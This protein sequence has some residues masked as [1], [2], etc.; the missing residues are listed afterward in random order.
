MEPG[1]RRTKDDTWKEDEL[2]KHLWAA[3]SASPTE[4]T[5]PRAGKPRRESEA[6]RSDRKERRAGAP[7][8]DAEYRESAAERDGQAARERAR[9][10]GDTDRP[11]DS[12][13]DTGRPKEKHRARGAEKPHGRGKERES[14]R[15]R[16]EE[17]RQ[18][19]AH[20]SLLGHDRDR[21]ERRRAVSKARIAE[22]ERRDED[23]ERGD[24]ERE[25]RYRERKLQY[26]DSKDN[27][28]KYWLYKE[29]GERRHR[30]QKEPDREKKH[31]EKSSTREKREKYSK[32]KSHSFSDKEGAERR[33]EQ[34]HKEGF[35]VDE[36]EEQHRRG[37]AKVPLPGASS[38]QEKG[39]SERSQ[40]MGLLPKGSDRGENVRQ[41]G[42]RRNRGASSK[43]DGTGSQ[44]AENLERN[45]GK[46]KDSRRKHGREEGPSA[47]KLAR[48]Q[49][50]EEALEIEKE[51][52]DLENAGADE[53]AAS[54]EADFEDYEGDFEVCDGDSDD[55]A[56]EPESGETAGQLPLARRREIQEVQKAIHAENERVGELFS[57]LFEKRGRTERG[58][59]PGPAAD[60]S[61]SETPACGIFLDFATASRRQKSRTQALKQKT[62]STKLLRLIDLD[63]SFTFSLLDLPPV[64]EY[65]MYIRNFGKKNTKQVIA[66]LLEEDRVALEPI[67]TPR[68]QDCTLRFSDSSAQLNTSLPFLQNR[69]VSYLHASQVQR[70]MV[71][72]V[73]GRAGKAFAPLLDGRYVL[74]VWD[75][76]QPSGPQKVLIC[77]S[78]VTCCCFSPLKAF[79]LFAGTVHGS[80]VV[81]DLREDARLHRYVKLSG[82]FWTFR[83]ATFSTDGVLMS[84][85]HRSP[86]Q[87][88]E[89]IAGSVCKR[90]S[91]VLSP[92]STQEEPAGL[93]FHVASLDESGVLN[94][95]V[96][97]ELAKADTAGAISDLGLLPG[98]RI[99]LVHSAAIQLSDSVS[100]KGYEFWGSTQTLNVKFLPSDPNHFVVGT[101]MGLISHGTRQDVRVSPRLFRPQQQGVRPVKVNV[102]DFSPFGE[103]IFLAGCSDGSIRLHQLTAE[104][105]L[106]Q[107]DKSTHGR[108]VTGLQ[109]S[110]T[111]P[112]VFLVQDDTSCVY[113]WDLLESD[114]GPVAK[115]PV[116]PDRLVAMTVVGEAEKTRSGFL[117]LVLARASGDVDVQYLRREWVAP[118]GDE[119]Q[120]LRLLLRKAL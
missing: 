92:F 75:I 100:H 35:R 61:P 25:R 73:H 36:E 76:W 59:G 20:P 102:I 112:A 99:K 56:H 26:G 27:P 18:V 114:L 85:N 58:R 13:R 116:S 9:G 40:A 93:S 104:H 43:T 19:A 39:T 90:Q 31:R 69:R 6:D 17:L 38:S 41:N 97:V 14:G 66:V 110:S 12:R 86:L 37:E 96:V 77:E 10:A 30:K 115:Q 33:K 2:R 44:H 48:R 109:W 46:D 50:S 65:D 89:P 16:P 95:W 70:R 53:Y 111:R 81:W 62:R 87:A 34:R 94:V 1:K 57:K 84:V 11:R 83:T 60:V 71:V 105:P 63:F 68:A 47:W 101:D 107:W 118:V 15:A 108:A 45:N 55:V 103:P 42:E 64:N 79:L 29:E 8:R 74:C 78:K 23:S 113:I 82:C 106:L 32:A 3:P 80:V 51:D 98:G 4:A 5:R 120:R 91:C 22:G 52:I 28:L 88:I 7:A 67:W 21:P 72:S 117:A 49:G 119:L 54:F 24:E